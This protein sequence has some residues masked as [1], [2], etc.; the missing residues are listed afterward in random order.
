MSKVKTYLLCL[1]ERK[2][3][4]DVGCR[5]RKYTDSKYLA[6]AK[7]FKDRLKRQERKN[8]IILCG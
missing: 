5:E 3:C 1:L 8:G 6:L 7:D 4:I 2:N